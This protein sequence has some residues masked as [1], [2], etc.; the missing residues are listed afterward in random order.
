[1]LKQYNNNNVFPH[2]RYRS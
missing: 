2:G 1:V